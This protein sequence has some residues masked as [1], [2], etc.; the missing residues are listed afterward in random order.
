MGRMELDLAKCDL[1]S[2]PEIHLIRFF[3]TYFL[4]FGYPDPQ[5]LS[6]V[7]EELRVKGV[8]EDN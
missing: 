7:Q 5:Y 4:S 6:R 3:Y 2:N 8:T 1:Y